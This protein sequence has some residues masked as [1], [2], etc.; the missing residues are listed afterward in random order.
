MGAGTTWVRATADKAFEV[1]VHE[2]DLPELCLDGIAE[3]EL[4]ALAD[5]LGVAYSPTCVLESDDGVVL[6]VPESF[7]RGLVGLHDDEVANVATRW[8][9]AAEHLRTF[10]VKHVEGS[11][12]AMI[13]FARDALDGAGVLALPAF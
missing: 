7:L 8:R 1:L 9:S 5:V 2:V 12:R 3:L 11:L 10:D 6:G 13:A 4:M